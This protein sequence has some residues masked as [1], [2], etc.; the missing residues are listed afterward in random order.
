MI[1]AFHNLLPGKQIGGEYIKEFA[2][3]VL[4]SSIYLRAKQKKQMFFDSKAEKVI[5][6]V[7]IAI[8]LNS[9]RYSTDFFYSFPLV[10]NFVLVL[11]SYWVYSYFFRTIENSTKLIERFLTVISISASIWVFYI[12]LATF[13]KYGRFSDDYSPSDIIYFGHTNFY[14]IYPMVYLLIASI[15][16]YNIR[17]KGKT[18]LIKVTLFI[19]IIIFLLLAKRTYLYLFLFGA[20]FQIVLFLLYKK[21]TTN[22]ISLL[23]IIF[24]LIFLGRDTFIKSFVDKRE[25]AIDRSYFE[26]GR[27]LEILAYKTDIIDRESIEKI[28]L[29]TEIF[30]SRQK[31]FGFSYMYSWLYFDKD[32]TLHSDYSNLLYGTG[33]IGILSYLLFLFWIGMNF[34]KKTRFQNRISHELKALMLVFWSVYISLLINGLSDGILS[35]SNRLIPFLLL[36]AITGYFSNL[37]RN[38]GKL[39]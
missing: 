5:F 19:A 10:I 2:I 8:L 3:I 4:F 1:D 18:I 29:G 23:L 15:Y 37:K 11:T 9:L 12:V 16:Y 34:Y 22:V 20:F 6:F 13:F 28:L 27:F 38:S 32:R 31:F 35:M 36:G 26:E 17:V 7:F 33:I 21:K 30:N 14:G 39:L 24:F 25:T